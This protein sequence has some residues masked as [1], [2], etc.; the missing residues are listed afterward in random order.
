MNFLGR[1]LI[2]F[3]VVGPCSAE[4]TSTGNSNKVAQPVPRDAPVN[5]T[6]PLFEAWGW[7]IGHDAG[8]VGL[9]IKSEELE[10]FLHGWTTA[11]DGRPLGHDYQKIR[12]DLERLA[13]AR[14]EKAL[15]ALTARNEAIAKAYFSNLE[16]NP[17]I[18]RLAD[19]VYYEIIAAGS[20]PAP[21]PEQTANIH[22]VGRKIDGTEF[23]EWGPLD[24]VLVPNRSFCRDWNTALQK[25]QKGGRMMLYIPPPLSEAEAQSHGLEPGSAMIFEIELLDVKDTPPEVLADA[26]VPPAPEPPPGA[27]SGLNEHELFE[28]WGTLVARQAKVTHLGLNTAERAWLTSGLVAAVR[29]QPLSIDPNKTA[30]EVD[31]LQQERNAQAKAALRQKH[32]EQS[33]SFFANLSKDS[34]VIKLPNGLCY[35]ILRPGKG[36]YPKLGQTVKVIYTG[37]LI[38]GTQFEQTDPDEP[39]RIELN[40]ANANWITRGWIEGIQ[41]INTGGKIRLCV[42]P[43][44]GYGDRDA[45]SVPA[46]SALI[47]EIDLLEIT[48][49]APSRN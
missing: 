3:C 36:A 15:R 24:T 45:N 8:L 48:S 28:L 11:F 34:D 21:K 30:T 35:Q 2:I 40:D 12:P 16:K 31:H 1:L 22:F 43:D 9:E 49:P 18:V 10:L 32:L 29:E 33:K 38:D 5:A 44:L 25:L 13:V 14:R 23:V 20:G 4:P 39:N 26:L 7:M 17:K 19:S 37:R 41:K 6:K 27:P 42:P 46:G 47:F